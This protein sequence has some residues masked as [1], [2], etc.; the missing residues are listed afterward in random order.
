MTMEITDALAANIGGSSWYE[1]MTTYY[2]R[3]ADGNLT[4]VSNSVE[5]KQ[6]VQLHATDGL[7]V[8]N[9]TRLIQDLLG[10]YLCIYCMYYVR[11]FAL[12]MQF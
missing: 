10:L 4:Y 5:F 8:Y 11:M 7:T 2:Q 6:R 3:N 12:A 1:I 9:E